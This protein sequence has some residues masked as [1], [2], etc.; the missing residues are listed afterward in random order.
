MP[1]II[2][3]PPDWAQAP[4]LEA[5]LFVSST[6]FDALNRVISATTPDKSIYRP[7][8]NEANLLEK[9]NVHL[10]GAA[11]ATAFVTNIDYNARGQRTR[12]DYANGASTS[13]EYD[14]PT[15]RLTHL[16]TTR[17]PVANGPLGSLFGDPNAFSGEIFKS[18][19]NAQ[20]LRYTYDP[21]GNITRIADASLRTVFKN[22][23]QIDAACNYTYD[24][25]YRLI[26]ASGREHIGQS[27][28]RPAPPGG[29]YRDYPFEGAANSA[30]LEA[31]RNY[32]EQYDYDSVGNFNRMIH[33]AADGNWTRTYTHNEKSLI[34]PA[35]KSNRLSQTALQTTPSSPVEPCLHDAHGNIIRMSHLPL[36]R[37]DYRDQLI[38]ISRQVVGAGTSETTYY[39][40]DAS[41]QRARKINETP[42]GARR[43]ERFY[44]GRFELY[45][46]YRNAAVFDLARKTLHVMDDK[47]RIALAETKDL[48]QWKR[49]S[50]SRAGAAL[51]VRKPS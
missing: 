11:A 26:E 7:A 45:K 3:P 21:A 17:P 31:L 39:V 5:G 38:A 12:I 24:A 34:E 42:G 36:M 1:P 37:W 14:A 18:P 30:D 46:E 19:T 35:K 29:N 40:Y 47:Q 6:A 50:L 49:S 8:F 44:L 10:R 20:D 32:S 27:T 9:V 43:N 4:S 16:S 28:F 48:C 13:Y 33:Q 2:R 51:S 23:Q 15:F 41:G 22:N 25:V